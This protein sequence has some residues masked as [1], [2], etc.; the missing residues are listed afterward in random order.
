MYDILGHIQGR[1]NLLQKPLKPTMADYAQRTRPASARRLGQ[2]TSGQGS[3]NDPRMSPDAD[4][5]V[6]FSDLTA[7]GQKSFNMAWTFYQDDL[8]AY[9]KQ[10][11]HI[12][13]F[14]EWIAA[15]VSTHYQKT[16]CKP[17]ESL[18]HWYENL[19]KAAGITKRLKNANAR[20]SYRDA[21]KTPKIKDLSTWVDNWEQAMTIAKDKEVLATTRASEWFEDF[22]ITIREIQPSWAEAYAIHKDP[23][24]EENTLDFRT[25]AN[26][27]RRVASQLIKTSKPGKVAKGS[28]G[29]TFAGE[30]CQHAGSEEAPKQ[31]NEGAT[32]R[33]KGRQSKGKQGSEVLPDSTAGQK[34]KNTSDEVSGRV[35]RACEGYHG[36]QYCYYL[37]PKKAPEEWTPRPHLQKIVEQNLK[38]DSTLKEEIKRWTKKGDKEKETSDE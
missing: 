33:K 30:E 5:R 1:E 7:D 14:K 22:L 36:T 38:E 2:V 17:T 19:K 37:F 21:L 34:R 15:N 10:Q 25:V 31:G 12:R 26:D 20:D 4:I 18:Q 23:F 27:L 9:E 29:P 3:S 35:C 24:V 6:V 16:C 13:K 8:K 32:K 28:F 11:E